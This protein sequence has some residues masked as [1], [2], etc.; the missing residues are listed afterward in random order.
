MLALA[1][2]TATV[3]GRPADTPDAPRPRD[4]H[5]GALPQVPVDRGPFAGHRAP[6]SARVRGASRVMANLPTEVHLQTWYLEPAAW[7]V[8][9][10]D[11]IVDNNDAS[12]WHVEAADLVPAGLG[13]DQVMAACSQL[14]TSA[15]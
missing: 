13:L 11:V 6:F 8:R 2:T 12:R 7:P 4:A 9:K 10:G 14:D 5:G 15:S 3:S 1:T